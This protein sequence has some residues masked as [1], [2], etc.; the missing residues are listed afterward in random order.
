MSM[1]E[2]PLRG[3]LRGGVVVSLQPSEPCLPKE[4]DDA[5]FQQNS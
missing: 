5:T 2:A 4:V 1:S 3:V